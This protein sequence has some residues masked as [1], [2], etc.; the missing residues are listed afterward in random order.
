MIFHCKRVLP[1]RITVREFVH[2]DQIQYIESPVV[3]PLC[4]F[5]SSLSFVRIIHD[6]PLRSAS[7]A[8]RSTGRNCSRSD[9]ASRQRRHAC[10]R[11]LF[12]SFRPRPASTRRIPNQRMDNWLHSS[13]SFRTSLSVYALFNYNCFTTLIELGNKFYWDLHH[14]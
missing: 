6:L 8:S 11:T 9:A 13:C 7:T 3:Y 12:P 1:Q 5:S 2:I 14:F 10:C 4:V